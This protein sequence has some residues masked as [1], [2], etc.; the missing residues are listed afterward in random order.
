MLGSLGFQISL[1]LE[2]EKTKGL[3]LGNELKYAGCLLKDSEKFCAIF[4]LWSWAEASGLTFYCYA[5]S[6]VYQFLM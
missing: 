3:S 2:W 6:E 4:L 5:C 1:S